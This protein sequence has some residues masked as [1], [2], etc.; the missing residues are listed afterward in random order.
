MIKMVVWKPLGV[1]VA[2]G[3]AAQCGVPGGTWN[4]SDVGE[5]RE[6]GED[7]IPIG[8]KT[9]LAART[10]DGTLGLLYTG[11]NVTFAGTDNVGRAR[12]ERRTTTSLRKSSSMWILQ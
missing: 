4:I 9:I 3:G 11:S 10:R 1:L 2:P 5:R 8:Q 7:S 6:G 12:A